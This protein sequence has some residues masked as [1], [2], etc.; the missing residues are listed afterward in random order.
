MNIL[1]VALGLPPLRTGGLTRYCSE[2]MEN[3][4]AAGERVSLVYPGRFLP[5]PVRFRKS[6][7]RGIETYELINP[8]PVALTF[9]VGDPEAFVAP[10]QNVDVFDR[11]IGDILPD[12][13]HVH[14][15]MGVYKEFFQ[16]IKRFGLPMVFT[17]HD[18]YPMC[19]R[20]TLIDAEGESCT[21]G[22][23]SEICASCCRGGMTK[24]K[25]QV[26]QSGLYARFKSTRFLKNV[27]SAVKKGMRST[28]VS[29]VA[30]PTREQTFAY[31]RLL[32]YNR[33]IFRLFDLILANSAMT[34]KVYRAIFPDSIYRLVH[35]SH[36][37]LVR[38]VAHVAPHRHD[39]TLV[40]G[41]F[42]GK[43][44]YKGYGTLMATAQ[45]LHEEGV[46]FELRLYGDEYDNSD[47]PEV[48]SL[49]SVAP[50]NV[51]GI[52]RELDGV[53]VPSKY[54]ETFGFVVLE[55]LCEGVPVISS[56]A[57]GASELLANEAVFPAG[58][59]SALA[60]KIKGLSI[61]AIGWHGVPVDYPLSM[62]RQ[63]SEMKDCYQIVSEML[64]HEAY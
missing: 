36:T 60:E 49:G 45:I 10:C 18:Y 17:T 8:L 24:R 48:H 16:S 26:M 50:E 25:S 19:P 32:E 23:S 46:A 2:L 21:G 38:S 58:D 52:L 43:K 62:E 13:V 42:G 27:S 14:S 9:G 12:V 30:I 5:G 53:V 15:F 59:A 51:R 40:L 61:G 6:C 33:S 57:V 54:H 31:D 29:T 63:V 47:I 11:L 4:V 41:Y 56:D 1:H 35:I 44:E 22:S 39:G 7:W 37:G 20:C 34:E 55:A 3:Q 28:G 64:A